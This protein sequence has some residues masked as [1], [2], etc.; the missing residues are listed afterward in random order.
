[1]NELQQ[2]TKASNT[3]GVDLR[4]LLQQVT[5]KTVELGQVVFAL[6]AEG[7]LA[8]EAIAPICEELLALEKQ[9]MSAPEKPPVTIEEQTAVIMPE[10]VALPPETAVSP[11]TPSIPVTPFHCPQCQSVVVPGK[12]ILYNLRF[13]PDSRRGTRSPSTIQ[14]IYSRSVSFNIPYSDR[15]TRRCPHRFSICG[16]ATTYSNGSTNTSS[17]N[18]GQMYHLW[19]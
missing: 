12:K 13:S 1:M 7:H 4:R 16:C 9:M 11:P 6:Y 17:L 14:L 3:T 18:A 2:Q 15:D 19:G 8:H 10:P 5:L